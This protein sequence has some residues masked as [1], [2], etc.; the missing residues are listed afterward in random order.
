[1]K[2]EMPIP[3]ILSIGFDS[4]CQHLAGLPDF[5]A[6]LIKNFIAC[7]LNA[8]LTDFTNFENLV[9]H[10]ERTVEIVVCPYERKKWDQISELLKELEKEL[11]NSFVTLSLQL[12]TQERGYLIGQGNISVECRLKFK[13]DQRDAVRRENQKLR[14]FSE[15]VLDELAQK[16]TSEPRVLEEGQQDPLFP[17]EGKRLGG[18]AADGQ[19]VR[20]TEGRG[21]TPN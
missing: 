11:S 5:D 13:R 14:V 8:S 7:T 16:I 2:K 20:V 17:G 9:F 19:E 6:G 1:L 10:E 21:P 18:S 15:E 4:V 12:S 3:E